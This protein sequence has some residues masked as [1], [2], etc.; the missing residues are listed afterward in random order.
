MYERAR[1]EAKGEGVLPVA[2]AAIW[3]VH[4]LSAFYLLSQ[5]VNVF[6]GGVMAYVLCCDARQRY[7]RSSGGA[8]RHYNAIKRRCTAASL[9]CSHGAIAGSADII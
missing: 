1:V 3:N 4:I 8:R 2:M 9:W 7:K 6:A 5:T